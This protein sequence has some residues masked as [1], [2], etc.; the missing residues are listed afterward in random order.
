MVTVRGSGE[1]LEGRRECLGDD[2]EGSRRWV[3]L[4][5]RA[6]IESRP[7]GLEYVLGWVGRYIVS[8]IPRERDRCAVAHCYCLR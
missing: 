3:S 7:L 4:C 8:Y 1:E 6:G 5:E 2:D